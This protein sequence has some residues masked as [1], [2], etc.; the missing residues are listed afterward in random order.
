[1]SNYFV[2]I[3]TAEIC[4]R[5]NLPFSLQYDDIYFSVQ[6][7]IEQS[8]FV[9]ISGNQLI[10][11]WNKL[12]SDTSSHFNIGETGFGSGLNF[13]LTWS[14]WDKHA[15]DSATL[16]FIS[17]EKHP[18][19]KNDL[20]KCLSLWPELTPYSQQLI[21]NY[22]VL[23][24]GYHQLSFA[25][26][27][28]QLTLMLGDALESYEQLLTCGDSSME[29]LL[30]SSSID[31]W[32]LDGFSPSKNESMWSHPLI[33][34]ISMLSK[35]GTTLA[36]YTAAAP[37]KL[38]LSNNGFKVEKRKGFG[39]KRHMLTA[40]LES[41]VNQRIRRPSTPWHVNSK[42]NMKEKK[43]IIVGAGLAGCFTAFSLAKRGWNVILMD[44][45]DQVGLGA[46]GNKRAVL[47]PKL[48]AYRSPFTQFMLS[49]FLYAQHFYK[50]YLQCHNIGEF[51]GALLLAYNEK[52]SR[53][54]HSLQQWLL[55]YPEL[56]QLVDAQEAS[57]LA[58][59]TLNQ[60]G[61]YIPSSGWLD[62]PAL[63]QRL[64]ETEGISLQ[65]K[66]QINQIHYED[67]QWTINEHD[68]PVLILA[69]GYKIN[70]FIETQHLP[71]KPIRGQMSVIASSDESRLLK[72]PLCADGHVLPDV[73]GGHYFGATYELGADDQWPTEMDNHLNQLKLKELSTEVKW[74]ELIVDHW[75]GVRAATPDYLPLVGPL[76]IANEFQALFAG[77]ESNA[78][79]WI[80][81]VGP[82]YPGLYVCSGFGSRGLTTVP[83]SAEWL[84]SSLNDEISCLPR[85]LIQALSP[86][87]FLR[88][89]IIRGKKSD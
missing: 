67:H 72:I 5:G 77:L 10:E 51:N 27:R 65:T 62:S 40:Y 34:V 38:N 9:F 71:I 52:E 2:P 53:A 80:P 36:T 47:F 46:S 22:P 19:T 3:K 86:A 89:D 26:G 39:L 85:H 45:M 25:N 59:V 32:Y 29:A 1:M 35:C 33:R 13:L 8:L 6:S 84:A 41:E 28:V 21:D 54:Q 55:C 82:Y 18:L 37:V 75:A 68:A 64:V 88:R 14:L 20:E 17:C 83:L 12:P 58:G 56:G 30:R 74:S 7:G 81:K 24:P 42:Q 49:A 16:H 15:P 23:T 48:S 57:L 61:L 87:R 44:E 76:P 60:S 79:R 69:N 4:W 73:N 66:V 31:A 70:Q 50:Q 78:N 63:C 43:A 11:R